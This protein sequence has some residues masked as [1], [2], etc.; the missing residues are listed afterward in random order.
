MMYSEERCERQKEV[1]LIL[2]KYLNGSDNKQGTNA[3]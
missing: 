2:Q 3:F 1:L